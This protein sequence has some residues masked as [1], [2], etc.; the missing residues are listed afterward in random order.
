[1]TKISVIVPIY[2]MEVYLEQCLDSIV[3][4]TMQ[5][6]EII[7]IND[8]STDTSQRILERYRQMYP[9][10]KVIEQT[11]QGV[12]RTRN[13]G[14]D[15]AKGEFVAFV[16]PDDWYPEPDVLDCLYTKAKNEK[17]L[18]CGGSF[19]SYYY[20]NVKSEYNSGYTFREDSRILFKDYQWDYGY[21]RFIYHRE[22]LRDNRI[23][24]PAYARYQDPPFFVQAMLQAREF[25]GLKKITYRYRIG[26]QKL[27]WNAEKTR[28]LMK[29][30]LDN[31]E[32][33]KKHGLSILHYNT[34]RRIQNDYAEPILEHLQKQDPQV[35]ELMDRI[36]QCIDYEM[37]KE[38]EG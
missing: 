23:Y 9:W 5:E 31:L 10:I 3:A 12:G 4:Q 21:H 36:K 15:L 11:N 19:S 8:G 34:V 6:K 28:D 30:L 18:I 25:Y 26:H 35:T 14:I 2:N 33:S 7:C 32:I 37:V 27:Q 22:M 1:M 13:H 20:G 24:F 38:H 29:G 16:D 17:V